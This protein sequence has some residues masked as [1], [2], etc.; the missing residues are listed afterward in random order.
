M[1]TTPMVT[2]LPKV[3]WEKGRDAPLSH[4]YAV[5]SPFVT[6]A[7]PK[8]APKCTTSRGPIPKPH[9]LPHP[10]TRSTYDAK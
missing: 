5:K 1:M 2:S 10:W 4:K 3:I 9:Y 6:M 7:R 8:F